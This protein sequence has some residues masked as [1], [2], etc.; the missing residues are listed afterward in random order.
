MA[1]QNHPVS[2]HF[3]PV[4]YLTA[5]AGADGR[6]MRYYRPHK[7]VVVSPIAPKRTGYEDHLYT[8]Q[9]VPPDQQAW[10]ETDFFSPVDSAAAVAH[11]RLLAGKLNSL[12]NQQRVDW[13]RFMMSMQSRSPFSLGE[14]QRLTHHVMRSRVGTDPADFVPPMKAGTNQ[15]MYEWT[16]QHRPLEIEDAHKKFLPGLIDHTDLGHYLVNMFWG[17]LNMSGA[18]HSLLTSDRPMIATHGWKDPWAVL[19]FPLSPSLL[20]AATNS[21]ERMKSVV[22]TSRNR[23][24]KMIN[25]E[26]V[27]NAVDFVFGADK[28]H[29]EFVRKRLRRP[30]QEPTPGPIGKG[31]PDCPP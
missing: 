20:F 6:V 29:L 25:A 17:T 31:R 15:T 13:A 14:V 16:K 27:R 9:G 4:F 18:S 19:L 24:V 7:D 30:D 22:D 23:H 2:H 10:L 3:V 28:N 21:P 11:Q 1:K 8:L 5:W 12:T 26:I